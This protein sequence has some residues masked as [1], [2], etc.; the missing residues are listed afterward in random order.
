[1]SIVRSRLLLFFTLLLIFSNSVKSQDCDNLST[2][3]SWDF[4]IVTAPVFPGESFFVECYVSGFTDL[5]AFQYSLNYNP[6]VL[7][8]DS[9]DNTGS[10]LIG[11][12]DGNF[13]PEAQATGSLPIL[14]TNGNGEGQT[15]PDN[16]AIFK[17]FFEVIGDP[18]ECS[19]WD[20]NSSSVLLEISFELPDGTICTVLDEININLSGGDLC[21]GCNDL[22]LTTNACGTTSNLGTLQ[23]SA[24]G[25]TPPYTYSVEG[26][27]GT[28]DSGTLNAEN[29]EVILTNL[30]PGL[31][32]ISLMDAAGTMIPSIDGTIDIISANELTVET[33]ILS[34]VPCVGFTGDLIAVA[35]GGVSPYSYAWSNGLF[36]D[37]LED[38][39]EG[40]YFVTVTDANGCE[41]VSVDP[42]IL[43][44]EPL[45]IVISQDNATC[46]GSNDGSF[47]IFVTGG[48]PVNGDQYFFDNFLMT[49]GLF[50][51][52]NPGIFPVMVRDE[53]GCNETVVVTIEAETVATYDIDI[54]EE[55]NCFGDEAVIE[56]IGDIN[57]TPDLDTFP[58]IFDPSGGSVNYG[59]HPTTDN[60]RI[61]VSEPGIYEGY[62]FTN[63]GC[64]VEIEFEVPDAPEIEIEIVD[65]ADFDCSGNG[66]TIE[67][68]I[69]GGVGTLSPEWSTGETDLNITV[70]G[71]GAYTL[72]VTDANMCSDSITVDFSEAGSLG[73]TAEVVDEVGCGATANSGSVDVTVSTTSTNLSYSWTDSSGDE[74]GTTAFVDGLGAGTYT[75]L[76]TDLDADCS[77]TDEVTISGAGT[78]S[79]DVMQANPDCFGGENGEIEVSI[80]GGTQPGLMFEWAH[81]DNLAFNLAQD[82][83]AG[84]YTITVTDGAGCELDTTITLENPDQLQM[85]VQDIN[86]VSCFNGADGS[87]I[88]I[89]S[90]SPS[91]ETEFTYFW[92]TDVIISTS[93][94]EIGE[95]DDLLSGELIGYAFDGSCFS[96]TITFEVP[97]AEEITI[98]T[99]SSVILDP[100]CAGMGNGMLEINVL[101][102][103]GSYEFEWDSGEMS[104][105]ISDLIEGAYTVTVT[106]DNNCD[107]D[108][109]FELDAPDSLFLFLNESQ[110]SDLSCFGANTAVIGVF[111]SGGAGDFEYSWTPDVSNT[112]IATEVGVGEYLI[113]VTDQLGCTAELEYEVFS[114]EPIEVTIAEIE[115]I[116]CSG[117]LTEICFEE[118]SGGSG[119]GFMYQINFSEN[120]PVD[121]CITVT[122]GE[123]N[124]NVTDGAGCPF[125]E[126]I[127]IVLDQPNPI[128]VILQPDPLPADY[129]EGVIE[130][131]LGDSSLVI[132]AIINNPNPI[133]LITWSSETGDWDCLDPECNSVTVSP[134]T[135]TFYFAEVIDVNGC[136]GRAEI[137][138][139]LKTVRNVYVPNVF[140]PDRDGNNDLFHP[141]TGPGVRQINGF[142][143]YDRWGNLMHEAEDID[144]GD[145]I[146]YAWDGRFNGI[147]V[148]PGVYVFITE[149]EFDDDQVQYFKGTVTLTR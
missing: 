149:V 61:T 147:D 127:N 37:M 8:F 17:L 143:I 44:A 102:G 19:Q 42:V 87:A 2:N 67:V 65:Q 116:P 85:S 146:L 145:E 133:E 39:P 73:L 64:R 40:T 10:P 70:P 138:I 29:E 55:I 20:I 34:D 46:D 93:F 106:D 35:D 94:G 81:D 117:G 111:G 118:V 128:S 66:G 28:I 112:N 63:D 7:A 12:V 53:N 6:N 113:Q 126:T 129:V 77:S 72:V 104:N 30:D 3:L 32:L 22:Y 82:L 75:V 95:P 125:E 50:Q 59:Y 76:V 48:T 57:R 83:S 41:A 97:N 71:S 1:M 98:D 115:D 107:Q 101:G 74:V 80:V 62:F 121:S 24:C 105:S 11:A 91:G 36:S 96:D 103:A 131:E 15:L 52:L 132:D 88:G 56:I 69:Q 108:F 144:P 84:D 120:T 148:V 135:S 14:W 54:I 21:V 100:N 137:F 5:L 78:F 92:E 45:N 89:A 109:T 140:S 23:F 134:T 49:E 122:A 123:Y 47:T 51:N 9:V 90:D 43:A 68:S 139:D 13:T 110:T 124:I 38:A 4:Q 33:A 130:L 58:M 26:P 114:S 79:F 86:G 18:G 142:Y 119:S 16:T 141:F 25:G 60:L 31:Y 136:T 99:L 27:G